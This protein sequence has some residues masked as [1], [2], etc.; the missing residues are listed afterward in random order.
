MLLPKIVLLPSSRGAVPN[1]L[2]WRFSESGGGRRT[3]PSSNDYN[4][5]LGQRKVTFLKTLIFPPKS[6]LG[7][8]GLD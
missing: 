6:V 8:L 7:I 2:F 5:L 4:I 3:T 1:R